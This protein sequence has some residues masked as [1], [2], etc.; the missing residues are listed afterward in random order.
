MG[1]ARL[2]AR[3]VDRVAA[4]SKLDAAY[5]DGQLSP[6]EHG[7]RVVA[8]NAAKTLGELDGLLA[9]L[10]LEPEFRD[11][12][13]RPAVVATRSWLPGA[14]ALALLLALT[15]VGCW[16][17]ASGSEAGGAQVPSSQPAVTPIVAPVVDFNTVAGLQSFRDQYRARFGDTQ[18]DSAVFYP[19][20]GAR[21][22]AV[23][24]MDDRPDRAIDYSYR[25]GFSPGSVSDR[26]PATVS[27]D[28]DAMNLPALVKLMT[29]ISGLVE[30]PDAAISHIMVDTTSGAPTI[31]IY[32]ANSVGR[33]GFVETSLA[34]VISRAVPYRR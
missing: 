30:V 16:F 13:I 12:P 18:A 7:D 22:A 9:D 24:R 29:T 23:V 25:G 26:D 10:Q 4:V 20:F 34:G 3:D 14:V 33:G 1:V 15:G 5:A 2:R 32:A 8:A 27:F 19:A 11:P 31:R 28:L 21:Y 17:V 6:A